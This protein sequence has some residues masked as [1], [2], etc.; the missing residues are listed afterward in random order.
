MAVRLLTASKELVFGGGGSDYWCFQDEQQREFLAAAVLY[1]TLLSVKQVVE[2][3]RAVEARLRDSEPALQ[4]PSI[5]LHLLWMEGIQQ[6][7]PELTLPSPLVETQRWA[8]LVLIEAAEEAL[9]D[10]VDEKTESVAVVRR[11]GTAYAELKNAPEGLLWSFSPE[12]PV[13]KRFEWTPAG[14]VLETGGLDRPDTLAAATKLMLL[15]ERLPPAVALGYSSLEEA[16][17]QLKAITP[18]AHAFVTV[19]PPSGLSPEKYSL[20]WLEAVRNMAVSVRLEVTDVVLWESSWNKLRGG[21]FGRKVEQVKFSHK[22]QEL[23]L[24]KPEHAPLPLVMVSLR[25]EGEYG[26]R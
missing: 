13:A 12:D 7:T 3:M 18:N 16:E 15:A 8:S 21:L 26:S 19:N 4:S 24:T 9:I 11:I 22:V 1:K 2:R 5:E 20:L 25:M 10:A 6:Q 14:L 17:E 23:K